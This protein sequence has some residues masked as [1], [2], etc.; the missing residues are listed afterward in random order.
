MGKGSRRKGS[1]QEMKRRF[2]STVLIL[3]ILPQLQHCHLARVTL[4]NEK[5]GIKHFLLFPIHTPAWVCSFILCFYGHLPLQCP[6]ALSFLSLPR[7][8]SPLAQTGAPSEQ[9]P[10]PCLPTPSAQAAAGLLQP[11]SSS[12]ARGVTGLSI[13]RFWAGQRT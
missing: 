5:V 7:A 3:S 10:A 4:S 1:W 11:L 12:A 9:V 13:H 6:P 2:S 8:T